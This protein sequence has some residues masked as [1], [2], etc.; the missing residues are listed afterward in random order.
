MSKG[1]SSVYSA[2]GHPQSQAREAVPSDAISGRAKARRRAPWFAL[3]VLT[4][5]LIAL[6]LGITTAL[7]GATF[8][9]AE[10]LIDSWE[11]DQGLPENSATAMVQTP[12]GYLW[13]GT[14]NGLVR[15]DG[16][17]FTV[18]DH[19]NTPA[20][21][22]SGIVNLHLDAS[23]R[24][25]VSTYLGLAVSEPDSWTTF[26]PIPG[27][28]GN[29][30][31]T[32]SESA[33]V[34]CVTSF[35]GKVFRTQG[36]RL[37]ELPEPPGSPGEG[38]FG[39]VDRAG[40]IW[41]AQFK[42]AFYGHWDGRQ[43]TPSVL[44]AEF[45]RGFRML[46]GLRNGRLLVVKDNELLYIEEE[47]IT[48]R[49][50][51]L[52]P[53]PL[54]NVW[55]VNE[56]HQGTVW[57]SSRGL[58]RV[59]P[60]GEVRYFS[61]TNGLTY[62]SLRFTFEDREQNLW[63]GTSGG[64][65][66]RFKTRTFVTYGK[67][68][69]LSE[70]NVKAV[71]EEAPGKILVGTYGAGLF[72]WEA[73]R[74]SRLETNRQP[75]SAWAEC[76]LRDRDRNF[77]IGSFSGAQ[78]GVALT[79]L[80]PTERRAVTLAE[81]GAMSV[82]A[83][84]QDSLGRVWIGG[85]RTVSVFADGQLT[86]QDPA[87]GVRLN[88]VR[89]FA[90]DPRAQ[91]LWAGGGQGLLRFAQGQWREVTD[92]AGQSLKEILCL[93]CEP[94]GALWVGGAGVG[95]LRL[96]DG[97][98]S[99]LTEE[100]GLPTRNISCIL[101]DDSGNW[102]LGSN[103]GV[104]RAPR[105]DF[106]RVADGDLAKLPCQVFNV[107]DG[108]AS[109]ECTLGRQSTGLRDSQGRLWFATHKG[110][111]MVDPRKLRVNTNP[112]PVRFEALS[113]FERGGKPVNLTS[114]QMR[115][116]QERSVASPEPLLSLPPG[117]IQLEVRCAVLSFVAPEKVRLKHRWERDG[118]TFL[119]GE[120]TDRIIA[121]P[122][123]PPGN[124]QLR[125]TAAN[126][127]GVWNETGATL[128]FVVR[129]FYWQTLWF[130]ALAAL[131]LGGGVAGLGERIHRNRLR[132]T[133]EQ[134]RQ[135]GIL[136]EERARSAAL[137]QHASDIITLLDQQGRILY[138]SP[139]ASRILGYAPGHLVGRR[140]VD[141]VHPDDHAKV[142]RQLENVYQKTNLGV[143]T[144]FRF[145][146]A[147]GHWIQLE[148]LGSNLLEQPGV[149]GILVTTR[150]ITERKQLEQQF[151]QA[152][153]MEA[154]GT[155]AGGI[156]HDFN[157]IL[158]GVIGYTD[159]ARQ[160]CFND[161]QVREDLDNV[162]QACERAKDLV[163]QILSFSRQTKP[164]RKLVELSV[165]IKDG[166]KLMRSTLPATIEIGSRIAADL[167]QVLAD[168]TQVHQVLMNLC[169][170]AAH[171]MRGRVGRLEVNL[172]PLRAQ[173]EFVASH[174]DMRPGSYVRLTVSDTGHGMDEATLK[175]VFEPFFTTKGPGEG[176]GLGLAVVHGIMRDHDGAIYVCSQPD[177]GTSF[178]LYFPASTGELVQPETTTI[179]L[180]QGR[181]ERILLVDD[182]PALCFTTDR[183]LR[184]LGYLPTTQTD[185]RQAL[186]L[187][188]VQPQ[189]FDLVIT[190]LT[191]PGMT[192]VDL[193]MAMLAVRPDLPV[194]LAS[195]FSGTYTRERVRDLGLRDLVLKPTD[196]A[197]L[198]QAVHLA[199]H[200]NVEPGSD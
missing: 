40:R 114:D 53:R 120:R 168:P 9:D 200:P 33:G 123:L 109:V 160:A 94:D 28:T 95:L 91:T 124:Y 90:E 131:V 181:Q 177:Q 146:H 183:V 20:L 153:K 110:V 81:G 59:A 22:S 117:S 87:A 49:L 167:P 113:Y 80:T 174:P 29:Y 66:L 130:G 45:Q 194:I 164:E 12:D 163:R 116:L 96:K 14:F 139:S 72:R 6:G 17:K 169:T 99:S 182:E 34:V 23:H 115:S 143:P 31:R 149:H 60:T 2:G 10:Y 52:W 157:N 166:L 25:W 136:A 86:P 150:D 198:S 179:P 35:D 98:W 199:L 191:M 62:D 18:F 65:L 105:A 154:M 77:W 148:A 54:S 101:E 132:R 69:G 189:A 171:A 135:Q 141:F 158:A 126:N 74:F 26:H 55:S 134:L 186:A 151:R 111:A 11:T 121:S 159:M 70:R 36:D 79:L 180:I 63:V 122:W 46:T 38:Y 129:P 112:P 152:Q 30:V 127:D 57:L 165:V 44:A 43:W 92:T 61:A 125:V 128:A 119:S 147:R 71:L 178:H 187:F 138:E 21:A 161:P 156:A 100:Q 83:L 64:G 7:A 193:A 144:E 1:A 73:S 68:N 137:T 197:Q 104:I 8:A 85:G 89:C 39:Y 97:H 140:P 172:E 4:V 51:L 67:G 58:Y 76:L 196:R 56:D 192:G 184:L 162:L 48:S 103:R 175:H 5:L 16:V 102:W 15:F 78:D 195:G 13:F 170:N 190:D 75:F 142:L 108:L 47:R 107:S 19:A 133:E 188:C 50:P 93:R 155:L 118:K 27:W 88:D 42:S 3:V 37:E 84:F 82:Q 173:E 145:R 106:L 185:P 41:V 176:T 24:L 32:F